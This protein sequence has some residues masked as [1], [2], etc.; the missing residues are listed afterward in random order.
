MVQE[1]VHGQRNHFSHWLMART[2]FALLQKRRP[3]KVTDFPSIEGRWQNLMESRFYPDFS[4]VAR[5]RKFLS[6]PTDEF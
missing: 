4:G 3:R 2:E 6:Q 1:I 5:S